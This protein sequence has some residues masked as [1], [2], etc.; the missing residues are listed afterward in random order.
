[1]FFFVGRN[2]FQQNK[3]ERYEHETNKDKYCHL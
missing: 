2:F 3:G 1:M